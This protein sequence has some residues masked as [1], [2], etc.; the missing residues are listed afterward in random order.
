MH[1]GNLH[2]RRLITEAVVCAFDSRHILGDADVCGFA[3]PHVSPNGHNS[4]NALSSTSDM[5]TLKGADA[6]ARV[7]MPLLA[8]KASKVLQIVGAHVIMRHFSTQEYCTA[9]AA[10][11]GA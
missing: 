1:S 3:R 9:C 6:P 10:C 8:S 4:S 7:R 5:S 2:N 11:A